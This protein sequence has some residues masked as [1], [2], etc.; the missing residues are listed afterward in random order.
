MSVKPSKPNTD[1]PAPTLFVRIVVLIFLSLAMFGNYYVYES[2]APITTLLKTQLGFDDIQIGTLNAIY[3][4]PNIFMLLISGLIV[5]RIGTRKALLLFASI[6][7]VGVVLTA[8]TPYFWVMAAGRLFFGLGAESMFVANSTA[9]GQWFVGRKIGLVFGL[10][11]SIGRAGSAMAD[12]SPTWAPGAYAAGWQGPLLLAVTVFCISVAGTA[13]YYWFERMSERRYY[14][15]RPEKPKQFSWSD[16]TRFD[17]SFWFIVGLCITFYSVIFPF[18]STFSIKYFQDAHGLTREY[19]GFLNSTVYFAA[20]VATPLFG[21]LADLIGRRSLLMGF[22]TLLLMLVFPILIF[23]NWSLWVPT[24]LLGLAFSLVP[25]VM[26]PSIPYLVKSNHLGTAF[27]LMF[28]L[29]NIGLSIFNILA[30]Y[31]NDS[32]NASPKNP[33]GYDPMLWLFAGTS[34]FG[35]LFA[36]LLWLRESSPHGHHLE[37]PIPRPKLSPDVE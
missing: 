26:W 13:L 1:R 10:N 32:Y 9:L 31:L 2:I 35:L 3:S 8:A 33:A 28:M 36:G 23:T 22:G 30:G 16:V 6:C 4:V 7:L 5:D 29:Q 34:L 24:L 18:R 27:G 12:L 20:I 21:L 15:E 14:L 19:A 17:L 25:A 11:I 37:Q